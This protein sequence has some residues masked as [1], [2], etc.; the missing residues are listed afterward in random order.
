MS[1][2]QR[3]LVFGV[4]MAVMA[5]L[6]WMLVGCNPT[7]KAFERVQRKENV[8]QLAEVC[9]DKFPPKD[10]VIVREQ[11]IF[12][13]IYTGD[14]IFDTTY[15]KDTVYITKTLPAKVITKTVEKTKEVLRENTSRV[16]LLQ[17]NVGELSAEVNVLKAELKLM[18]ER[19]EGFRKQRNKAF[20]WWLIIVAL[21]IGYLFRGKVFGLVKKFF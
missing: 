15:L 1:E 16:K 8:K 17:I 20:A 9:V 7:K 12:D 11:I 21:G 13:T 3:K 6:L 4:I 19:A 2:T 10:C 18:T 5:V 14:F